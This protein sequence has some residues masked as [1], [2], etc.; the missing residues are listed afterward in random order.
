MTDANLISLT[1]DKRSVLVAPGTTVLAAAKKLGIDIPTLCH[2]DALS[3]YASCRIC[4]VEMSIEKR[5]KTS[6]WI[7]ASCA[8]PVENG[9]TVETNSP[10]VQ[11]ERKIILEF[12]LS[13]APHSDV[14][15]RMAEKYGAVKDRF[16]AFDNGESN[17]VLCGLCVRVCTEQVGAQ[18]IGTSRRGVHKKVVSPC[19]L[20]QATCIGCSAC[21]WICPTG[22]IRTRE[23]QSST[24]VENWDAEL[25][26][27][28]CADCGA[29]F[30]PEI[31]CNQV[32]TKI[33]VSQ[34]I[35]N[36][37]PQCRRKVYQ[38]LF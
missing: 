34:A 1:I 10:K 9:L 19:G 11:K 35:M 25:R 20:G 6:R 14:L 16:V 17:C 23:N 33:P 3:Q 18:T 31:Y 13:R 2:H 38:P 22:A 21:S 37:C 12:L 36:K 30:A 4:I 32:A 15:L 27:R 28:V 5:G 8:Y 24:M 7:D 29:S 26:T